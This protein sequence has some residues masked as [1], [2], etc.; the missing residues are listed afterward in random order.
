ME[1]LAGKARETGITWSIV[2][3]AGRTQ[4]PLKIPEL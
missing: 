1:V 2:R 4:V 3:D